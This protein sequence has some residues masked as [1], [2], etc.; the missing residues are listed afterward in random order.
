MHITTVGPV[1]DNDL[2]SPLADDGSEL[3]VELNF[4]K[5]KDF[6]PE[7]VVKQVDPAEISVEVM[8]AEKQE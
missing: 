3:S 1:G 5:L 8:R 7:G 4:Q 2:R 6:S